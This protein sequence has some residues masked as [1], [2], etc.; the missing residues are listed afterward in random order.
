MNGSATDNVEKSQKYWEKDWC[1]DFSTLYTVHDVVLG[2][3]HVSDL[4]ECSNGT[5]MCS[6]NADC[7][8][9]MGS[10]RCACKEGFSG[11]GF[12]CSGHTYKP[13]SLNTENSLKRYINDCVFTDSLAL[14]LCVI[15]IT[16]TDECAENSNLCESGH[17][18]NLPGGFRCECDMGFI[19]T[20]DGKACEGKTLQHLLFLTILEPDFW[21]IAH[22]LNYV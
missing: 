2:F 11:D 19:P 14:S 7:L 9:T 10:Y 22:I 6:N 13:V 21:I 5:H 8:N 1:I 4:D 3:C 20:P 16:D 17:C 15:T 12:Y 18:L